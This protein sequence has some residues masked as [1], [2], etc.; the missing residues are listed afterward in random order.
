MLSTAKLVSCYRFQFQTKGL[1]GYDHAEK[2]SSRRSSQGGVLQPVGK[3]R[4]QPV[5]YLSV[6]YEEGFHVVNT[7][8]RKLQAW[9]VPE[10]QIISLQAG[11]RWH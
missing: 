7:V 5:N 2:R 6:S 10:D 8:C 11:S 9:N 3:C 1:P 4:Q